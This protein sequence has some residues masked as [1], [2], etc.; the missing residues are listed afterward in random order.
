MYSQSRKKIVHANERIWYTYQCLKLPVR[1][2]Y[3][4]N[5]TKSAAKIPKIIHIKDIID[6][7]YFITIA[8]HT[9]F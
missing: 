1:L 9:S 4:F 7:P 6:P 5:N 2:R 3:R 8:Y